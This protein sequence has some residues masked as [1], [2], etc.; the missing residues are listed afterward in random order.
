MAEYD[1]I[2]AIVTSYIPLGAASLEAKNTIDNIKVLNTIG[3]DGTL[4]A[5]SGNEIVSS[6]FNNYK[7]DTISE[8]SIDDYR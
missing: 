2:Y 5:E 7:S 1:T 3:G 4:M 8:D 6:T